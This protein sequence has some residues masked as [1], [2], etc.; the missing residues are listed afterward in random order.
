MNSVQ[1]TQSGGAKTA[2]EAVLQSS[3]DTRYDHRVAENLAIA[4]QL[5][6]RRTGYGL[7]CA[8]CKTYY[9]ADLTACPVCKDSERVSPIAVSAVAALL[10]S[11]TDEIAEL[12][13][14]EAALEAERERFLRE[15]KAQVYASHMQINAAAS[16]R[17]NIEENHEGG[18]E[19]AAVCQSCYG[20]LQ[21]RADL[22]EAALHI[23]LK[24][25]AQLVYDAVWS[26]PS[27]PNKTYLNAA[28]AL[29]TELRK[30]AG[31]ATVLGPLQPL[32]H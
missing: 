11:S 32:P 7:P 16:F 1:S 29:L 18:F 13:P 3:S 4:A 20:H 23:D 14:D 25:A 10:S 21:E 15:F 30:R 2:T 17:C 28:Q 24:E 12:G 27:D 19:P 8:K 22:M 26:D 5:R 9:A 31:I 6:P